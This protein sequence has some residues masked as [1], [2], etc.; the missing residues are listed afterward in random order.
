MIKKSGLL[1]LIVLIASAVFASFEE[2]G[3]QL[4][5]SLLNQGYENKEADLNDIKNQLNQNL[6]NSHFA[7]QNAELSHTFES[8][9]DSG[10]KN[11]DPLKDYF[12]RKNLEAAQTKT[13]NQ[14]TLGEAQNLSKPK[15]H[16]KISE[17]DAVFKKHEVI[18]NAPLE[19]TGFQPSKI[20]QESKPALKE[21]IVTCRQSA[22][23]TTH[24]CVKRLVLS[25]VPQAPIVKTVTAY[26]TARCYNLVTFS[27]NL[28]NGQIGVYQC[29]NPGPITVSVDNP[30]GEPELPGQTTIQLMSYQHF[31]E[32]GVD[33]RAAQMTPTVQNGF[34]AFFTAFQPKT[35]RKK[36]HEGNK[37]NVRG[38]RYTWQ[39]T[40]PRHPLL[41]ERWEGCE[42]LERQTVEGFCELVGSEQQGIN[43]TRQVPGYLQPVTR[44]HWSENK[45]FLCGIGRDIDECETYLEQKC[46]QIDSRC[47]VLKN[48]VCLEFENTFK[49]GVPDYLKGDGLNFNNGNLAF[50]KTDDSKAAG[51]EAQDFG[52]AITHFK[53]LTEIGQNMQD[54]LGGVLGDPN[55]PSV[56]HGQCR[57]CRV[58][59]GSF[60]RDCCKL[61]GVL[62][63]LLG[64]CN[65]EEKKLAIAAIKN[66]RCVKI[67]GRYCHR[68]HLKICTEKRDSYC[69]YGSQLAKIIQEIAHQQL[70]I[71]WGTAEHPNCTSLTSEQL[72]RLNFDTPFAQQK[73]GEILN[74]VQSTAQEKFALT[75]K[76]VASFHNPQSK[77]TELE[78]KQREIFKKRFPEN[79]IS[80]M[81]ERTPTTQEH[82]EFD[83]ENVI[84]ST[85][86][87]EGLTANYF[88][89]GSSP[90][91][92]N[93]QVW[94][95]PQ[96]I[97][98]LYGE[99]GFVLKVNKNTPWPLSEEQKNRFKALMK[100]TAK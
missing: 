86:P 34:T 54:A 69:C 53:A 83:G 33:F 76:V 78:G 26:F 98:K 55:N 14:P 59:L 2:E 3:R 82:Y 73:L 47:A 67:D 15:H 99:K 21:Q 85:G 32:G 30:I 68:K 27:I 91:A 11:E 88:D 6:N 77:I 39:V 61:K 65:E 48:G 45:S 22:R 50:A 84:L 90:S 29:E 51:Y 18:S 95:Q 37:N 10:K 9:Y 36:K 1:L 60:V 28:N 20:I 81:P 23:P 8:H 19:N 46:E 100:D 4:G 43:E 62:Q 93:Q 58:N 24:T 89:L 38:G 75:Q 94:Y 35:G 42:D 96:H 17:N 12:A 80:L 79:N 49:C 64:G 63:G 97:D 87:V 13:A 31:G 57:Q 56:F 25:T 74:E 92:Q 66:K 44:N 71:P 70:N 72:S 16:F 5:Q 7:S 41:Q 52:E 40:L